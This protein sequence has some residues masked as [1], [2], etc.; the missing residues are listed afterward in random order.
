MLM[1][2]ETYQPP[3][4]LLLIYGDCRK[5]PQWPD[6]LE[7]GFGPEHVPELIRMATDAELSVADSDS[8]EVWAPVHAWRTLA[9]LHAEAAIE[10]LISLFHKVDDDDW[11]SDD[12][13]KV[14]GMIGP[15]AIPPLTAYLADEQHGLWPRVTAGSCLQQI[16][17]DHP[18][19]RDECVGILTRQLELFE[20]QDETF[21]GMLISSLEDLKAVE[22]APV[23]GGAFAA[24]AVDESIMGDWEDVQVDLGL[25]EADEDY[26]KKNPWV[27][28]LP[29]IIPLLPPPEPLVSEAGGSFLPSRN[30]S[31]KVKSKTKSKRKQAK[32]S[33]KKNRKR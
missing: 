14:L 17:E 3:V 30:V 25:K 5:F 4:D 21:N 15:A 9:Q 7:L 6:Y 8:M 22:A 29:G 10:P 27:G 19:S 12:M 11:I 20:K 13:P 31:P 32:S 16:G 26:R 33:R 24:D 1:A 18:T 23:M 28:A 2:N